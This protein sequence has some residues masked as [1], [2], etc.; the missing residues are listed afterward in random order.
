MIV[1]QQ[2]SQAVDM[3]KRSYNNVLKTQNLVQ[4]PKKQQAILMNATNDFKL[5]DY[6][7]AIG[8]IV[9]PRN[10]LS[11]SR[12]ANNRVCIYLSSVEKVDELVQK[13][14]E[15]DV[16]GYRIGVRRLITPA[17]RI[18]ISNVCHSIPNEV[19]SNLL[20]NLG[21]KLVSPVTILRAGIQG[22]EYSHILSFRRQVYVSPPENDLYELPPSTIISYDNT[23]YRIFIT[24]DDMTCF[25]CKKAGH[26]ARNCMEADKARESLREPNQ[27]VT[28][29]ENVEETLPQQ[30]GTPIEMPIEP[31]K[32]PPPSSNA[33]DHE[34]EDQSL[35]STSK[36]PNDSLCTAST[37][38]K[39]PR[40]KNT[41]K[42]E[43]PQH[44]KL[45]KSTSIESKRISE[46]LEPVKVHIEESSGKYILTY[47]QFVSFMENTKGSNDVLSEAKRYTE[48]VEELVKMI[49]NVYPRLV[50]RAM[51]TRCTNV[52]KK[53]RRRKKEEDLEHRSNCSV[54]SDTQDM[55]LGDED[56]DVSY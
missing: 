16:N 54:T 55:D 39:Q 19:V 41:P 56:D 31:V 9:G 21:L 50:D 47:E 34:K 53:L 18:V 42:E 28:E 24:F 23:E 2:G 52:I 13:Y 4:F 36:L 48:E 11:A 33:S 17:K 15:V 27:Q 35:H 29:V 30:T 45:K 40:S 44:K 10:I 5:A 26:I 46:M 32:R 3:N 8:N 6:V 20:V 22:D 14:K 7:H 38:F 37:V 43:R 1:S 25:V 12:I 51:K 49:Y